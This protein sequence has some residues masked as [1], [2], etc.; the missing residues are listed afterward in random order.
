M[1][2][3]LTNSIVS[4]LLMLSS[5]PA[6]WAEVPESPDIMQEILEHNKAMSFKEIEQS[7][8]LYHSKVSGPD[9]ELSKD[10]YMAL[11]DFDKLLTEINESRTKRGLPV[12]SENL[13]EQSLRE[14]QSVGFKLMDKNND[15]S[16]NQSEHNSVL[17]GA[18]KSA[19]TNRDKFLSVSEVKAYNKKMD[20]LM[21]GQK[22]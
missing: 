10:E 19:D 6:A 20:D 13:N 18:I 5:I 7:Y 3:F 2:I 21:K 15:G 4:T 16:L 22:K 12:D 14:A 8:S 1:R 17:F 11:V 9:G